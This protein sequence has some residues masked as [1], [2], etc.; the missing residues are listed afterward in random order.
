MKL[1][2]EL[3]LKFPFEI[4]FF[5]ILFLVLIFNLKVIQR[6]KC[7]NFILLSGLQ[8]QRGRFKGRPETESF[9]QIFGTFPRR[10]R[11]R[12]RSSLGNRF[13]RSEGSSESRTRSSQGQD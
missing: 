4:Q 9:R 8:L 2:V 3:L 10:T 7:Q 13:E 6:P 1:P 11:P 12:G 5:F